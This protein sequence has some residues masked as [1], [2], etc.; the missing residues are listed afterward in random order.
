MSGL[1]LTVGQKAT[2]SLTLTRAEVEAYAEITG[3]RNPLHFDEAFAAGTR[4]G[5]LVVHGG[6]TAG[7]LNALVAE[8]LPGPGTVF[9]SQELKYLAPVF[10]GDTITGEVELLEIHATKPVTRLAATVRRDDGEVVLEGVCWC[11]TLRPG[12]G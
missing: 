6:L 5:R 12:Q 11:Y 2:R 9:M 8:D 4:F 7:I 10:V 1:P 3:D